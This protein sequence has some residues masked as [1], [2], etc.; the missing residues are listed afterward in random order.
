MTYGQRTAPP[1]I[2]DKPLDDMEFAELLDMWD[3][4][5]E[6]ETY[7]VKHLG[8]K[9]SSNNV[10]GKVKRDLADRI[11]LQSAIRRVKAS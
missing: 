11:A 1:P 2:P 4:A 9:A 8:Y 3:R 6:L 10:L 5:T 7:A